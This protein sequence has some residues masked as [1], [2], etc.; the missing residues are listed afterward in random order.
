MA[1]YSRYG[2]IV[3]L[4]LGIGFI[5]G[6]TVLFIVGEGIIDSSVTKVSTNFH[7]VFSRVFE[8]SLLFLFLRAVN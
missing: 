7:C 2:A 1:D 5:T 8:I 4:I 3:L 6:G